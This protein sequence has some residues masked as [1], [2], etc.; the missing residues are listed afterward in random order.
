LIYL[1]NN[2]Q[3]DAKT[4]LKEAQNV[5]SD[6]YLQNQPLYDQVF[7]WLEYFSLRYKIQDTIYFELLKPRVLNL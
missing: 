3:D 6:F 4:L 5:N 7:A 2:Q 1:D